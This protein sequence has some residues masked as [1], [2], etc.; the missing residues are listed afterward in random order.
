MHAPRQ[1]GPTRAQKGPQALGIVRTH[2]LLHRRA[3]SQRCP[4]LL[5]QRQALPERQV[6]H[7]RQGV[8][9][10]K[11]PEHRA[12]HRVHHAKVRPRKVRPRHAA[13]AQGLFDLHKTAAQVLRAGL[14]RGLIRRGVEAA[15]GVQHRRAKLHPCPVACALQ[16]I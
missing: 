5:H 2:G 10:V 6:I 3:R 4:P 16:R 12:K 9:D 14:Q 15:D 11:V 7:A 1:G 8:D 13:L